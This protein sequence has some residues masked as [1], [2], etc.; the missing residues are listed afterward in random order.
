MLPQHIAEKFYRTIK[1][2]ITIEDFEQWLY[3][4]KE[5]ERLLSPDDYLELI[6][7]NFKKSGAKY[8]LWNLLKKQIDLGEY[9][10]YKL[11]ELLTEAKKNTDRLPYILMEF[12][13]LYCR[14]YG[15]LQ[16]L[17]LNYGLSVEAPTIPNST[18][19]TWEELTIEQQQELL[20]S[21]WPELEKEVD[22]VVDWLVSDKII[23]TGEKDYIG[24]YI[25]NDLRTQKERG[26]GY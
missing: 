12:Y 22:R 16:E 26:H 2:D 4:D 3:A 1:G 21:F 14:G 20:N 9:E 18:A 8:E 17:G 15:F 24:D 10:T 13:G 23:L 19:D 25:Y 7:L 6:A 5:I 11:V